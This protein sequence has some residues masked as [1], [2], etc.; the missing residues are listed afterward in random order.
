MADQ[1]ILIEGG[2]V[3]DHDGETKARAVIDT[4]KSLKVARAVKI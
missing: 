1:R 3:Y 4:N 2:L